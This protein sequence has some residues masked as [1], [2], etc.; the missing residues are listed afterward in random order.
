M[1]LIGDKLITI[2]GVPIDFTEEENP[3]GSKPPK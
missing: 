1:C 2:Q 3:S